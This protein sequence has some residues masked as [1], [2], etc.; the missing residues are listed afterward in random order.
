MP[1]P[2]LFFH[3]GHPKTGTTSIQTFLLLNRARLRDAGLLYPR[4][5]LR[6]SA[7]RLIC[8]T[9]YALRHD[10]NRAAAVLADLLREIRASSLPLVVLSCESACGNNPRAFAPLLDV[11]DVTVVYYL[12]RQDHLAESLHAQRI[13]GF[14]DMELRRADRCAVD[15]RPPLDYGRTLRLFASVFGRDRLVVRGFERNALHERDAVRD[16]FKVIGVPLPAGAKP[17]PSPNAALKRRYLAFKR[18]CNALPLLEAEHA[19]LCRNLNALSRQDPEPPLGHT[20]PPEMRLRILE[21]HRALNAAVAREFLDR[22]DGVLFQDPPPDP[23]EPW[24]SLLPLEPA[25]QRVVFEKLSPD[26]RACLAFLSRP[27]RL[28][29]AGESI[30]PALP[31]D[32]PAALERL[33][34]QR[35]SSQLQRRLAALERRL[36][37]AAQT[38]D[39]P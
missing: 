17:A 38:P 6:D 1:K 21:R 32:D 26:N 24:A 22:P 5:G 15:E 25:E 36:S 30:L 2:R 31:D 37:P 28:A 3:I 33:A 16:F 19:S 20:L 13:R 34:D 12:R 18:H 7:H 4:T 10:A 23:G 27:A 9:F 39:T 35:R 8:P 11:A 29:L 14:L